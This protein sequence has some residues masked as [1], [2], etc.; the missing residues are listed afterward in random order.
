MRSILWNWPLGQ[1]F[2]I[3][4][5]MMERYFEDE[6]IENIIGEKGDKTREEDIR[7]GCS[8][9][10]FIPASNEPSGCLQRGF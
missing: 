1:F 4:K 9:R 8:Y 5:K 3:S 2:F 6:N 7:Y 10:I